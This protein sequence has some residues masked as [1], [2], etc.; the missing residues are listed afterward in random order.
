MYE[1][2]E[3][4]VESEREVRGDTERLELFTRLVR[5]GRLR[6]T[7]EAIDLGIDAAVVRPQVEIARREVDRRRTS[8]EVLARPLIGQVQRRRELTPPDER[9]R[10]E[11]AVERG[12]RIVTRRDDHRLLLE[13]RA[14][15]ELAVHDVRAHQ[16]ETVLPADAADALRVVVPLVTALVVEERRE[17]ETMVEQIDARHQRREIARRRIA[18][19]D[20]SRA[21]EH[22][23]QIRIAAVC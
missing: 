17:A 1:I 16:A 23:V 20:R 7:S 3:A 21:D 6:R 19:E 22:L 5:T 14:R 11:E 12:R 15:H 2:S 18:A 10:L 8:A 4:D 9:C 13:R